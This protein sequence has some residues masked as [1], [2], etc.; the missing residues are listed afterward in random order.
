VSV[1]ATR[2][3]APTGRILALREKGAG[4]KG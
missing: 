4:E 1:I 3:M 2:K